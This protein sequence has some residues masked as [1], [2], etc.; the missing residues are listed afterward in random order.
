MGEAMELK[1]VVLF[2]AP[3][4][5]QRITGMVTIWI[6]AVRAAGA[7][8]KEEVVVGGGGAA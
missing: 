8:A 5:G 4:I 2:L 6:Q 7:S 1:P 3:F